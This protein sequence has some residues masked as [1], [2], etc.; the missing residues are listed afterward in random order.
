MAGSERLPETVIW[1]RSCHFCEKAA[2]FENPLV[3]TKWIYCTEYRQ[4]MMKDFTSC[5]VFKKREE[6][7]NR[8]PGT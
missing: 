6:N 5:I 2:R 8:N 3:T 1:F 4:S 7:E